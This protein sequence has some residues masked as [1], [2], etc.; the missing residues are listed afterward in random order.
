[1]T[2]LIYLDNGATTR[3]FK[4][5]LE[6]AS[7]INSNNYFNASALYQKGVLSKTLLST[8]DKV[9]LEIFNTSQPQR[10]SVSPPI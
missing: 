7:E 1:M 3:P 10:N 2:D 6:Y 8:S 4:K 5:S 9:S